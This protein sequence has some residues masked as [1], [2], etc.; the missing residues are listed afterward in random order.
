MSAGPSKKS[1]TPVSSAH[2][3]QPILLP[4]EKEMG[5]VGFA[6]PGRKIKE[7]MEEVFAAQ[8]K[9]MK[10]VLKT[11]GKDKGAPG[12]SD[13]GTGTA[14]A[15]SVRFRHNPVA[16]LEWS[17]GELI[18]NALDVLA[19]AG[20]LKGM[21]I[22]FD[23]NS[24]G[25]VSCFRGD[26]TEAFAGFAPTGHGLV[27]Y[28]LSCPFSAEALVKGGQDNARPKVLTKMGTGIFND[29]LKQGAVNLVADGV[30][31]TFA[32]YGYNEGDLKGSKTTYSWTPPSSAASSKQT[33]VRFK[34]ASDGKSA[35]LCNVPILVQYL[36]PEDKKL[37]GE[38]LEAF[39]ARMHKAFAAVL[40]TMERLYSFHR[41]SHPVMTGEDYV[42]K[43][44]NP[45]TRLKEC[46]NL[47]P[48]EIYHRD[49]FRLELTA[50]N[51]IPM[52]M[53]PGP[54]V[55]QAE[56]F[57]RVML[58]PGVPLPPEMCEALGN[59]VTKFPG[60]GDE[61]EWKTVDD[62][63]RVLLLKT[64]LELHAKM[65]IEM[66]VAAEKEG[67]GANA[68]ASAK[69]LSKQL[70]PLLMG[71]E[72]EIFGPVRGKLISML[73]DEDVMQANIDSLRRVLVREELRGHS[74]A[75]G[76]SDEQFEEMIWKNPI[77]HSGDKLRAAVLA[78]LAGTFQL[79]VDKQQV[80]KKLYRSTDMGAAEKCAAMAVH[81][82]VD[83]EGTIQPPPGLT[84]GL[85]ALSKHLSEG[86]ETWEVANLPPFAEPSLNEHCEPFR[87]D[88]NGD[89]EHLLVLWKCTD[90]RAQVEQLCALR[91]TGIKRQ[92]SRAKAVLRMLWSIEDEEIDADALCFK[93]L[94]KLKMGPEPEEDEDE[95]GEEEE[96][97]E[98]EGE[99][100]EGEGA[101]DDWYINPG[102]VDSSDEEEEEPK[103][104]EKK[105]KRDDKEVPTKKCKNHFD[106][107]GK[108]VAVCAGEEDG[109][110]PFRHTHKEN[111]TLTHQNQS[112]VTI[113]GKRC[114]V[115]TGDKGGANAPKGFHVRYGQFLEAKDTVLELMP[116]DVGKV[117]I[118]P[119][120]SPGANWDGLAIIDN[121][122]AFINLA[123]V[124]VSYGSLETTI[125]H[126][127]AHF[128][129]PDE[130]GHT[131]KFERKRDELEAKLKDAKRK[132]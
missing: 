88:I 117:V 20:L 103:K 120:W 128:A 62:E 65:I 43:I 14:P 111:I 34:Q 102:N 2:P 99:E 109:T 74:Q 76:L 77:V 48:P 54:L 44:K 105:R 126:E 118:V 110:R 79:H 39:A 90:P 86:T 38:E 67:A 6:Y 18:A 107:P 11:R 8:R 52:A 58:K 123:N 9:E 113:D 23:A 78:N 85:D 97:E 101:V 84:E 41:E 104:D 82:K 72:S 75:E 27:F 71:G 80:H 55:L 131:Q 47:G 59:M 116:E 37:K 45:K 3:P 31:L 121:D 81:R 40:P 5:N 10:I 93:I 119:T 127:L 122:Y 132:P 92:V 115:P 94:D 29:G 15:Y 33:D 24:K 130:R 49:A 66:I 69:Q 36:V 26:E 7:A 12:S 4:T 125:V 95:E 21:Q 56:R 32:F 87:S 112:P 124:Y 1:K 106:N 60:K 83:A 28:N 64:W 42:K 30:R 51:K 96:G 61:G 22:R 100:G 129:V 25:A 57:M 53:P 89:T 16:A 108:W 35:G 91:R 17:L 98:E 114:Y 13:T 19:C 70:R 63:N 73:M 46:V 50:F 68:L